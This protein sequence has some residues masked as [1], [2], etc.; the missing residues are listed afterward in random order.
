MRKINMNAAN[1]ELTKEVFDFMYK[2]VWRREYRLELAEAV[3]EEEAAIV[4]LEKS[5]GSWNDEGQIDRVIAE[6]RAMIETYKDTYNTVCA[7]QTRVKYSDA[8]VDLFKDYEKATTTAQIYDAFVRFFDEYD[9]DADGTDFVEQLVEATRGDSSGSNDDQVGCYGKWA[10][11][12]RK[13]TEFCK[14]VMR[15]LADK[16]IYDGLIRFCGPFNVKAAGEEHEFLLELPDLATKRANA[17]LKKEAEK[18]AKRAKR[19][20][21]ADK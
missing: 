12:K 16:M 2:E 15:R 4:G 19:A 13:K 1:K 8:I 5:R 17:I 21:K 3:A 10:L 18:A 11:T 9:C 20:K 7:D 14:I 6:R